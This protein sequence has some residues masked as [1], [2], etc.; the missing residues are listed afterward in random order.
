MRS[1]A[2]ATLPLARTLFYFFEFVFVFDGETPDL[3]KAERDRRKK[4]KL[5]AADKYEEAKQKEDVEEMKK[6]IKL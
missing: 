2:I 5:E 1:A 6:Y 4:L 3:K